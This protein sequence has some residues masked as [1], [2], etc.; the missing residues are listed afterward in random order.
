MERGAR[1]LGGFLKA[2]GTGYLL[3]GIHMQRLAWGQGERVGA[4]TW[5]RLRGEV[6]GKWAH[7]YGG[8]CAWVGA[9]GTYSVCMVAHESA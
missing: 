6:D 2:P 3:A 5:M 9:Q 1:W 7:M 8:R 4:G